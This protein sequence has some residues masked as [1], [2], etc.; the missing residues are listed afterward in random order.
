MDFTSTSEWACGPWYTSEQG[1][2]LVPFPVGDSSTRNSNSQA[3]MMELRA[4]NLEEELKLLTMGRL[5]A[6]V[7]KSLSIVYTDCAEGNRKG[8]RDVGSASG[9]EIT[10]VLV[11]H[12]FAIQGIKPKDTLH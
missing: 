2:L 4:F 6:D 11:F 7:P 12:S 9:R 10:E 5:L 1:L 3:R 8:D